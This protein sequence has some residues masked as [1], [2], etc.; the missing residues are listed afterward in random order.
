MVFLRRAARLQAQLPVSTLRLFFIFAFILL[1]AAFD[2]GTRAGTI[3]V[4]VHGDF[5][6]ALDAAQPGDEI[7]LAAGA[8]YMGPFTLP[9]KTGANWI[10]I[11]TSTPDSLLPAPGT[12]I[13]PAHAH[14]LPKLL[15]PGGN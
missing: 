2:T 10:T 9:Y 7:V 13:T 1:L 4:P 15:S 6:A 8:L 12:R 3:N 14:L 5:Q 11:R